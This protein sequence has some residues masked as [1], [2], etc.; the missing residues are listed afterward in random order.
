MSINE[1]LRQER[2]ANQADVAVS[3]VMNLKGELEAVKAE[4]AHIRRTGPYNM[5][6]YAVVN[7]TKGDW[8]WL[9]FSTG[10]WAGALS[11]ATVTESKRLAEHVAAAYHATL[12]PYDLARMPVANGT[13]ANT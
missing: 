4:L 3:A 10:Q 9:D 2:V 11:L 13:T 6:V 1:A 12:V 8:V 7:T 5:K